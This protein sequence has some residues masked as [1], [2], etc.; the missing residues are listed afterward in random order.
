MV[1]HVLMKKDTIKLGLL[2]AGHQMVMSRNLLAKP[3]ESVIE[4]RL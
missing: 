4:K 2:K 3:Q 1:L